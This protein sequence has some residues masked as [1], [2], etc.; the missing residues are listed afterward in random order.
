MI[1]DR[2]GIQIPPGGVIRLEV[3]TL[4]EDAGDADDDPEDS[5]KDGISNYSWLINDENCAVDPCEKD[6]L[7]LQK[8]YPFEESK[9]AE[10]SKK[11]S[12]RYLI[13]GENFI[14]ET[15]N[16]VNL[17]VQNENGDEDSITLSSIVFEKDPCTTPLA[18]QVPNIEHQVNKFN[19]EYNSTP[20][21]VISGGK[22]PYK[23]T[24]TD[25]PNPSVI[26]SSST[27]ESE[28]TNIAVQSKFKPPS[29]SL[30]ELIEGKKFVSKIQISDSCNPKTR[31][32][33]TYTI[34][35]KNTNPQIP[36]VSELKIK[37]TFTELNDTSSDGEY[38][39]DTTD[40][41]V[42]LLGMAGTN[43]VDYGHAY[44]DLDSCGDNGNL[45]DCHDSRKFRQN[46]PT[47]GKVE[48]FVPNAKMTDVKGIHFKFHEDYCF[49][50]GWLDAKIKE[51]EIYSGEPDNK[52]WIA[53]STESFG[54]TD[55]SRVKKPWYKPD[56]TKD[57]IRYYRTTNMI[58]YD[59]TTNDMRTIWR[60]AGVK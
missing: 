56:G 21:F 13:A 44:Y 9:S 48:D 42:H 8:A 33:G 4:V 45:S 18:L 15:I 26:F 59:K 58:G 11:E 43:R 7:I 47:N 19:K 12:V 20:T 1:D 10:T 2:N 30:K 25:N 31:V 23:W 50:C 36:K 55:I 16:L 27:G 46:L 6:G 34:N 5:T 39:V 35:L 17:K 3:R 49:T 54:K 53:K 60:T 29:V 14:G 28:T 22:A 57:W 52:V 51:F 41:R 40:L 32:E 37:I 24:V 38:D